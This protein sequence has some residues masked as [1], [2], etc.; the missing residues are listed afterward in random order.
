[1]ILLGY[2]KRCSRLEQIDHETGYQA[3]L[4]SLIGQTRTQQIEWKHWELRGYSG[5]F[6]QLKQKDSSSPC[7]Y[8]KYFYLFLLMEFERVYG[9]VACVSVGTSYFNRGHCLDHLLL[10]IIDKCKLPNMCVE[11]LILVF[12]KSCK[13][14]FP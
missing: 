13:C 9:M 1:M 6:T 8:L 10:D 12:W 14:S 11:N 2:G 7:I 3:P 4:V 5:Q